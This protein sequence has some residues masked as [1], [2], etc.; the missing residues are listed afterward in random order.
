MK[1]P[2]PLPLELHEVIIDYLHLDR[3]SL[4]S[5]DLVCKGWVPTSRMHLFHTVTFTRPRQ[6]I[7]FA[8]KMQHLAKYVK[9]IRMQPTGSGMSGSTL[10]STLLSPGILLLLTQGG[11]AMEDT[12]YANEYMN[13]SSTHIRWDDLEEQYASWTVLPERS[14]EAA[15]D[16]STFNNFSGFDIQSLHIA[17]STR[18]PD[19][20]ITL[21]S[22]RELSLFGG[23]Y[24]QPYFIDVVRL[25]KSCPN[26]KQLRLNSMQILS[27]SSSNY[28]Q[29]K[30]T[31]RIPLEE[32]ILEGSYSCSEIQVKFFQKICDRGTLKKIV[33]LDL[34]KGSVSFAAELL[35]VLG[36]CIETLVLDLARLETYADGS[37]ENTWLILMHSQYMPNISTIRLNIP[38]VIILAPYSVRRRLTNFLWDSVGTI[39]SILCGESVRTISDIPDTCLNIRN[40]ILAIIP[41]YEAQDNYRVLEGQLDHSKW[42]M[43]AN[44]F[45]RFL[46]NGSF[47]MV[48]FAL[49]SP[50][51]DRQEQTKAWG[52]DERR[53]VDENLR[54]VGDTMGER[55]KTELD[56]LWELGKLKI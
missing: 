8:V 24:A 11:Q 31:P 51:K 15:L 45:K 49:R 40:I 22:V 27:D 14:R 29:Q 55:I 42:P 34:M 13:T 9:R 56:F 46:S 25:G 4:A 48:R 23:T 26:V 53:D 3:K 5:C 1:S 44:S 37:S 32:I 10:D 18:L 17:G 21:P 30:N 41:Q 6:C 35:R 19:S 28:L 52:S 43:L 33:L 12:G 38:A 54:T 2:P 36:R 39:L 16:R 20:N 50:E 7:R 47:Q